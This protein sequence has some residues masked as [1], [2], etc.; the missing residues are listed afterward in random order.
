M[1]ALR[2][3]S[4]IAIASVTTLTLSAA[5]KK[6]NCSNGDGIPAPCISCA[7]EVLQGNLA[8]IDRTLSELLKSERFLDAKEFRNT[9]SQITRMKDQRQKLQAYYQLVGIDP[10]DNSEVISFL[11]QRESN[12][13]QIRALEKNA[14][15]TREQAAQ[16][17]ER[18]RKALSGNLL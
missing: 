6:K 9:V 13:N 7:P 8:A 10:K 18:L 17:S 14:R 4:L 12:E 3:T 16:V 5:T 2:T 1:S 11:G 15:I